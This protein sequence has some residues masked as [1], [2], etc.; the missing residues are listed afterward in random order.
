[1]MENITS[2]HYPFEPLN[3]PSSQIRL[4]RFQ[5]DRSG[6]IIGW[7]ENYSIDDPKRP[8]FKALSY[9]W[10]AGNF[11]YKIA[12][13]GHLYLALESLSPALSAICDDVRLKRSWW[14]IDCICINQGAD[15]RAPLERN[16]QVNMMDKIYEKAEEVVGWLGQGDMECERGM[17]FS[18]VLSEVLLQLRAKSLVDFDKLD[19]DLKDPKNWSALEKLF[20]QPWWT[21]VWTLQEYV[22]AKRFT[23]RYGREKAS[24][25]QLNKATLAIDMFAKVKDTIMSSR[26]FL[27]A[28]V[29]RRMW[30]LY[31]RKIPLQLTGLLAYVG[32]SKA[33]DP[34][35][36]I[37]SLLGLATDR[38]LAEPPNYQDDVSKVYIGFVKSF[39]QHY[40]NLDV[41][42]FVDRFHHTPTEGSSQS[43]LPSWV[44]D[45][46]VAVIPGVIPLM[47]SQTASHYVGNCRPSRI[48]PDG[49]ISY[50]A[51]ITK[52]PLEATFSDDSRILIG[53]GIMLDYVDG[54]GGLKI[55]HEDRDGDEAEANVNDVMDASMLLEQIGRCLL[56]NRKDRYLKVESPVGYR[57][58]EFQALCLAAMNTPGA[59][60]LNPRFLDWFQRNKD[61][62]I[63]GHSLE[64]ICTM[65]PKLEKSKAIKLDDIYN[66]DSFVARFTDTTRWMVR[67]LMTTNSGNI[68]VVSSR[69]QKGDQIWVLLGCSVPVVL[70]KR[71]GEQFC[72]V[73]GECYLQGYMQGE[74]MEE[75]RKGAVNIE[76]VR[77]S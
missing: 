18:L 10:G 33:S 32:N 29:R 39:V 66:Q 40:N 30:D 16:A 22:V 70:R 21:R 67:R 4:C 53:K 63:Q 43:S 51:G 46:R 38:H 58:D 13:N 62:Q 54:V 26:A 74:I 31:Q 73:I 12:I 3:P 49:A 56:L 45:W 75:L 8:E 52:R 11:S 14:W 59:A 24:R 57:F 77:L 7:L 50:T 19:D 5:R 37:F 35:D 1:M 17:R 6:S 42:C 68:G 76:E 61:L 28:W 36:R 25:T 72:E 15:E 48:T 20:L 71:G 60:E 34:R 55:V 9:V 23:F 69:A 44:P 2:E 65:T 27:A 41:I 47:V 64:R